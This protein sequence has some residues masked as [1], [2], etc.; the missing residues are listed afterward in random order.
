M[1]F[2]YKKRNNLISNNFNEVLGP[3]WIRLTHDSKNPLV[4]GLGGEQGYMTSSQKRELGICN[5]VG[6]MAEV[7]NTNGGIKAKKLFVSNLSRNTDKGSNAL[8][9]HLFHSCSQSPIREMIERKTKLEICTD[10]APPYI[11][12]F[13]LYGCT[14]GMFERFPN[15]R[16]I[17]W[18]P[19]APCH[20][21]TDLDR[22]FSSFSSWINTYQLSKRI[23]S[24]EMMLGVLNDGASAANL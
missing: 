16:L 22:R 1:A 20:G 11:S 10:N 12:R 24:V 18:A 17:R 5:C 21:K 4:I 13:F 6:L 15:L 19:L 3:K 14:K 2:Y 8:L 7:S 23:D 9:E